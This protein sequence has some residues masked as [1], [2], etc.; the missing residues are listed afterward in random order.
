MPSSFEKLRQSYLPELPD[1]LKNL[2][3]AKCVPEGKKISALEN[4][5]ELKKVFPHTFGRPVVHLQK[6]ERGKSNPLRVGV[7]FS[8]G[9]APG[10]HNVIAGLFDGLK[11]L[12]RESVLIGFLGGPEGVVKNTSKELTAEAV[13]PFRN[14]GGFDLI[15]SGR[16]KIETAEQLEASLETVKALNLDGLVV[17]GGDD[18]NTNAAI[19]AEYFLEKKC[20]TCV[21]GIPKTIDGDLKNA[22]VK[23][24]FGFD[25]ACKVYSEIIGNL[26]RDALSAKKYYHFIKLMG[27]SASH[28]ALECTL[29]SKCNKVIIGEEVAS[30]KRTLK[31]ITN[32]IV[33]LICKRAEQKKNYGVVLIPEGLIEFIPEIEVLLKEINTLVGE[34]DTVT[35]EEIE[36]GLFSTSK[37]CFKSLPQEIQKQLL[38]DRDAHGNIQV[39]SIETE[40]LLISCVKKALKERA[41]YKGKFTPVAHFLGYEGRAAYPSNFDANYCYVLGMTASCLIN[42]RCTG[43]MAFVKNLGQ[44]TMEWEMGALPIT[45]LMRMELRKGKS[46][47]VIQKAL[48]DLQGASYLKYQA[49]KESLALEDHYHFCPPIQFF[50]PKEITDTFPLI[51]EE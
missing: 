9:Q 44:P 42:D 15:G 4:E 10:G 29:A 12:H 2:G 45:M 31:E 24:S 1:L 22:Y 40:K 8:G 38:L 51:L 33:E 37:A 34:K 3:T 39:S 21:I 17:I 5:E 47:P 23:I 19:L 32:E 35:L 20:K 30:Y 46:K 50:G 26:E 36:K 18:S 41:D 28:I 16:V 27:R 11:K 7:V 14:S 43:Y 13:L 25:T 49:L 48:V 6:G